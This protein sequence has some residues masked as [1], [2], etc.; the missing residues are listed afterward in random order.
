L[1]EDQTRCKV[2]EVDNIA[3]QHMLLRAPPK[4]VEEDESTHK[5]MGETDEEAQ[6]LWYGL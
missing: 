6:E 5:D 4:L 3:D 2:A 1:S